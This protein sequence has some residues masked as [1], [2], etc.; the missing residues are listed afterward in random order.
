LLEEGNYVVVVCGC[1]GIC[2]ATWYSWKDRAEKLLEAGQPRDT[3]GVMDNLVIEFLEAI[4]VAESKGE[5]TA[6]QALRGHFKSDFRASLAFLE[7]RAPAR[8][9]KTAQR[10][11]EDEQETPNLLKGL[12]NK[13]HESFARLKKKNE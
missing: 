2:E 13:L 10:P 9:G 8:W 11:I 1:L 7:R 6:V 4:N 3:L 5:Q 12:F